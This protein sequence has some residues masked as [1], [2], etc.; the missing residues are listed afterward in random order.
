MKLDGFLGGS[1]GIIYDGNFKELKETFGKFL[2]YKTKEMEWDE[3]HLPEDLAV[4]IDYLDSE[5][6]LGDLIILKNNE[7]KLFRRAG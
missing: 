4:Y 6:K 2:S 1:T 7:V 3:D 5:I